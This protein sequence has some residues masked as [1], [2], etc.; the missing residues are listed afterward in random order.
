MRSLK[1]ELELVEL[2]SLARIIDKLL[3]S[4]SS[5]TENI[6][7]LCTQIPSNIQFSTFE[8]NILLRVP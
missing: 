8:T 2:L 7:R 6:T 5:L 1:K 4:F 3:F